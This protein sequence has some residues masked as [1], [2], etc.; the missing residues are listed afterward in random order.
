M[1][2]QQKSQ[3]VLLDPTS[4]AGIRLTCLLLAISFIFVLCTVPLCFRGF[5]ADS[6]PKDGSTTKWRMIGICFRLLMYLNHT[7]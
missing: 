7:V 4:A 6:L 2:L 3:Q 5:M 1:S